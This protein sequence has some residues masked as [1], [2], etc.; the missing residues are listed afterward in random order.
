[1]MGDVPTL[2]ICDDVMT[3]D[4]TTQEIRND[5]IARRPNAIIL[6]T[7]HPRGDTALLSVGSRHFVDK[8]DAPNGASPCKGDCPTKMGEKRKSPSQGLGSMVLHPLPMP[9]IA[10]NYPT[11]AQHHTSTA[12]VV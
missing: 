10:S 6:T 9:S 4:V 12:V 1:M 8:N 7:P 3:E 2:E 5:P 11:D